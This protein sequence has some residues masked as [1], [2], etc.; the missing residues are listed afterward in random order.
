[1]VLIVYFIILF[2]FVLAVG[3]M[4]AFGRFFADYD[5]KEKDDLKE[6]NERLKKTIKD[7][8]YNLNM[9]LALNSHPVSRQQNHDRPDNSL[10]K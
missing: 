2:A 6:E 9:F 3:L 7:L 5:D 1:M 10:R 8:E 4:L